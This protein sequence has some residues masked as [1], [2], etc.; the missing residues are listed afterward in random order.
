MFDFNDNDLLI[1]NNEVKPNKHTARAL[2]IG[3]IALVLCLI[4][5]EVGIFRIEDKVMLRVSCGIAILFCTIPQF[6]TNKKIVGKTWC[7]YIMLFCVLA[8]IFVLELA[9]FIFAT[10][11]CLLPL[12]LAAEYSSRKFSNIAIL[13]TALV[14]IITVPLGCIAGFW[15]PD[16]LTMLLK[17]SLGVTFTYDEATILNG[18]TA[19]G[20]WQ[21]IGQ[22][23]LYISFPWLL[24]IFLS[25]RII[26]LMTK[27]GEE[28][29]ATQLAIRR[30]SKIDSLTGLYNQNVYRGLL[31]ENLGEGNVGVMFFDVDGLKRVNDAYGHEFGDILLQNCAKSLKP[32]FD[33]KCCGFRVGGDEFVVI[34][35]TEDPTEIERKKKIWSEEIHCLNIGGGSIC[36]KI[37]YRMSVGTAF[38]NRNELEELVSK[39]DKQMYEMKKVYHEERDKSAS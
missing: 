1:E 9:L 4:L 8:F 32:L 31:K 28:N 2:R 18:A 29:T 13:G 37:T 22:L 10:P 5:N 35:D 14:V 30:L 25:S 38:G 11:I 19:V 26:Q 15:Q 23:T 34:I 17:Y 3:I 20:V 7:K 24:C 6:L 39:A 16:F 27:K 21:I 12:L 36:E 33:D